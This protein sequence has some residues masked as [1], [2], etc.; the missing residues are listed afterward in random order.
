MDYE[1]RGVEVEKAAGLPVA[2]GP[3]PLR[4]ATPWLR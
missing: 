2:Y 1:V 3:D 4:A